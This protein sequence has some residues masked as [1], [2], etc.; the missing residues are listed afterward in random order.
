VSVVALL[1]LE[2]PLRAGPFRAPIVYGHPETLAGFVY[3][4][5]GQQFGGQLASPLHDLGSRLGDLVDFTTAQLGLLAALVPFA[6]IAVVMRRWR[7]VVLTGPTLVI[8]C[9]FAV[10][11]DNAEI[12]RYY[13][14]PLLIVVSWLAILADS[15]VGSAARAIASG[16]ARPS[17]RAPDRP[18][19][20]ASTRTSALSSAGL[21]AIEAVVALALLAPAGLAAG[22]TRQTVDESGSTSAQGWLDETLA[23]LEPNAVVVSWWSFSTPLWYARDVQ[24]RRTD[25]TIID[26][27]TILDQGLGDAAHVIDTYLGKRPVY[28]IRQQGDMVRLAER[29]ELLP[30]PDAI[31]SGLAQVLGLRTVA[32]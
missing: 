12:S 13:L 24:G 18:S 25:I 17:V 20:R 9:L 31:H 5:L 11:Y 30:L 3:V 16:P 23:R 4:A 28:V 10:S 21:L 29:Y 6:G 8:T 19:V 14:G 2:L 22:V 7:Y 15:L 1:Y 26:D 32:P 27:R